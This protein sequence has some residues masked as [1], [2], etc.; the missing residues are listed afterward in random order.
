[1]KDIRDV[2][3]EALWQRGFKISVIGERSGVGAG[4]LYD[5]LRKRKRL[6]ANDL[7]RV[8]E[9]TGID[10]NEIYRLATASDDG[11]EAKGSD[12]ARYKGYGQGNTDAR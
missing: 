7:F 6:E 9:V 10:P 4:A 3:D 11:E 12:P 2:L 1:M 8:C 5:I